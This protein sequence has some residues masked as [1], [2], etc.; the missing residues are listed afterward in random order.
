MHLHFQKHQVYYKTDEFY[1]I[2]SY[3]KIITTD[4]ERYLYY[5]KKSEQFAI[6]QKILLSAANID[7]LKLITTIQLLMNIQS[8]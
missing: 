1:R 2:L 7:I 4:K 5:I 3:Q 6:L 8:H